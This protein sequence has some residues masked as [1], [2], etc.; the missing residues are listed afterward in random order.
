MSADEIE[1]LLAE[2][3]PANLATLDGDGFPHVTPIWFLW[4]DGAF[5]M[6][7]AVGKPHLRRLAADSRAGLNVHLEGPEDSSGQR[8]NR[9]VRV[10]GRAEIEP[11]VGGA[12]TRRITLRYLRGPGASA[13][14][15][16]RAKMPRV[17]IRIRPTS[18]VAVAS[19]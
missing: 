12:V 3:V 15:E 19:R 4:R 1:A 2:D 16:R 14:A 9:Q 11:D 18:W 10:I 5:L 6:T 7:S 8:L 13:Q 17:V